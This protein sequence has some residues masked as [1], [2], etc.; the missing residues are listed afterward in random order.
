MRQR[1]ILHGKVVVVVRH[2]VEADE[3]R[4]AGARD[5]R[6]EHVR[7]GDDPVGQLAAVAPA[8]DPEPIGVEE[9]VAL[10][11]RLDRTGN[12]SFFEKIVGSSPPSNLSSKNESG[13][14][15]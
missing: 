9:G 7:L 5:R 1:T 8:F 2:V 3:V 6:L 11:R 12:F 10:E 13:F 14:P 15:I 4:D